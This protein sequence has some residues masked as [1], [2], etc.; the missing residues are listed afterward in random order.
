MAAPRCVASS[1]AQGGGPPFATGPQSGD[2]DSRI[3]RF[4]VSLRGAIHT[5]G[6]LPS[7]L[8]SRSS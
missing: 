3:A 7:S 2:E 4:S 8:R 1:L 6:R 5:L